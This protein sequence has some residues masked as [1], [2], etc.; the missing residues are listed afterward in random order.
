MGCREAAFGNPEPFLSLGSREWHRKGHIP[1]LRPSSWVPSPPSHLVLSWSSAHHGMGRNQSYLLPKSRCSSNWCH[2]N[3]T[4]QIQP[5]LSSM[6]RLRPPPAPVLWCP[7]QYSAT[8]LAEVCF[9][10]ASIGCSHTAGQQH[11]GSVLLTSIRDA[12][13]EDGP[14]EGYPE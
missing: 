5:L 11:E 2:R 4:S 6:T 8:A 12:E 10:R 1:G 3:I 14:K 7:H 9:F 13:V